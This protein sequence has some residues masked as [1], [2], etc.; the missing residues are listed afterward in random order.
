MSSLP[1]KEL[2]EATSE[3]KL[4]I[5]KKIFQKDIELFAQFFFKHHLTLDTP[6]F[7]KELYKLLEEG[8]KRV[9]IAAPRG[10]AK[11]TIFDLIYLTW[12][13]VHQKTKFVLLISDTYSQSTLFLET[14]KA[15]FEGNDR[16]KAFYGNM[17]TE[18]WSEEEIVAGDVMVKALGANMKVRGLKYRNFR[19]DI[20]L[21]DDLENDEMVESKE[22]REKLS[23]WFN[24]A[25]IPSLAPDGKVFIIGTI[26]HYDSLLNNL[27]S[28]KRYPDWKKKIYR[29]V[30]DGK[31]LWPEHLN[32]KQLEDIKQNYMREGQG[33][34]FYQEYMNDP[35]SDEF[36]KFK[37][38]KI[39]FF[40]P[41]EQEGK[42]LNVY[43]A[44]DRAY[45][46]EKTA[47]FT[48]IV[49][50]GVDSDNR[51]Y[52]LN[53]ERFKGDEKSLIEK[54][55]DLKKFYAPLKVGIEQRSYIYTLKPTLDEEMR[56]RNEFF[57]IEE[58]RDLGKSKALRIEALLP[59]YEANAIF[60][61]KGQDDL[62]DELTTF[63]RGQHDD[64]IDAL[65]Y[66]TTMAAVPYNPS[67][68]DPYYATYGTAYRVRTRR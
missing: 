1:K 31:A 41:K 24:G 19:P 58:L 45:S 30:M 18:K 4:A 46:M 12:L 26:L 66:I 52:I 55:F 15:E 50:A 34:L 9:A 11:S 49:I 38:E 8:G 35:V 68:L 57:T 22:R 51:W 21:C 60:F 33:F 3:E 64:L 20:V 67:K 27:V 44:I 13:I 40:D 37:F 23:R 53:A 61:K 25:L 48:G 43:M 56:R 63:P 6:K 14:L 62:I 5:L 2:K 29:A 36:R 59:R 42:Q 65:A 47:D 16:L 54:I 32:L 28:E 17:V 10:H 7:H 39:K